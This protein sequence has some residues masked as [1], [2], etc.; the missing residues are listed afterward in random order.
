MNLY[1]A[2]YKNLVNKI[3]QDLETYAKEREQVN[4]DETLQQVDKQSLDE[5]YQDYMVALNNI[6]EYINIQK[7]VTS[8]ADDEENS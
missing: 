8:Y 7:E 6:I 1:E 4:A 5:C 3:M 2:L